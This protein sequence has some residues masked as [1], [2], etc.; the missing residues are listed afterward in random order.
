MLSLPVANIG[1]GFVGGVL[2]CG[3]FGILLRLSLIVDRLSDE[4]AHIGNV[5]AHIRHRLRNGLAGVLS[6]PVA[7][8]GIGFVGCVLCGVDFGIL[9]RLS[10][11]VGLRFHIPRKRPSY[12]CNSVFVL[13]NSGILCSVLGLD[14]LDIGLVGGI[15]T[16]QSRD[17]GILCGLPFRVGRGIYF[18]VCKVSYLFHVGCDSIATTVQRLIAVSACKLF[19][20]HF[21]RNGRV[22]ESI[23]PVRCITFK[24]GQAFRMLCDFCRVVRNVFRVLAD[25]GILNG[26]FSFQG[27]NARLVGGDA[28][29]QRGISIGTGLRFGSICCLIGRVKLRNSLL[30]VGGLLCDGSSIC[31]IPG[32]TGLRFGS[33][34]C[35]IGRVKLRNSLLAVG[36]LLCD[37]SSVCLLC[38]LCTGNL[39]VQAGGQVGNVGFNSIQTFAPCRHILFPLSDLFVPAVNQVG[40]MLVVFLELL[41][42][43]GQIKHGFL[44]VCELIV[45][46]GRFDPIFCLS[47]RV[48]GQLCALRHIALRGVAVAVMHDNSQRL[49]LAHVVPLH[50]VCKNGHIPCTDIHARAA[51]ERGRGA[52]M[53]GASVRMRMAAVTTRGVRGARNRE[54]IAVTVCHNEDAPFLVVDD[55]MPITRFIGVKQS[56]KVQKFP[57]CG[58]ISDK[59]PVVVK[60]KEHEPHHLIN[61][62]GH[63]GVDPFDKRIFGEISRF[64]LCEQLACRFLQLRG[65]GIQTIKAG[66]LPDIVLPQGFGI[67]KG[68]LE[69]VHQPIQ[70]VL[71]MVAGCS[72]RGRCLKDKRGTDIGILRFVS[73]KVTPFIKSPAC[74]GVSQLVFAVQLRKQSVSLERIG[75]K[76][77]VLPPCNQGGDGG[78][79]SRYQLFQRFRFDGQGAFAA[80]AQNLVDDGKDKDKGS[81]NR[82]CGNV[83]VFHG[84]ISFQ[85]VD[86]F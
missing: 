71:V 77:V 35:L 47:F 22:G 85:L 65:Q 14:V 44:Q 59:V 30:A 4:P 50:G 33:I 46:V 72:I 43:S 68:L 69:L 38:G 24:A 45:I 27:I 86:M 63:V 70:I 62:I 3:N 2:C 48:R 75:G 67:G 16:F 53:R 19:L 80:R 76:A 8:I 34:C 42:Q 57:A 54:I 26:L 56:I 15:V 58:D 81:G 39:S 1:I 11:S 25:I 51:L 73:H 5:A 78:K 60:A 82:A 29:T 9:C 17:A 84:L 12:I 32:F 55:Q 83:K 18:V 52:R 61:D 20:L 13:L 7:N 79:A 41:N 31:G 28:I 10:G 23:I 49:I 21:L 64:Q 40:E 6:L 66:I 36:G 37:G 74:A